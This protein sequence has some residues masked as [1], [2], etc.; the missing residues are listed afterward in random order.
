MALYDTVLNIVTDV[1]VEIGL[2][3]PSAVF[4]SRDNNVIQLRTLLKSVGRGLVLKNGWLQCLKEHTFTTTDAASYTLP[5]DYSTVVDGT[6]W[7]RTSKHPVAIASPQ[8]WQHIKA[9]DIGTTLCLVVK[10]HDLTLEIPTDHTSGDTVAFEYRSRYWVAL[11]GTTTPTKDAPTLDTDVVCIDVQLITRA[12]KL[13]WLRAKGF[14]S[15]AAL[16]DFLEAFQTVR[17][18]NVGAAPVLSLNGGGESE[19]LLDMSNAPSSGFG[20]DGEGGLF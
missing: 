4:S 10:P 6:G 13:A 5:A 19:P 20:L 2:G 15:S 16:D 7:N 3:A 14:D 12:L 11:T 18:A 9:R 1:A 17:S 8:E